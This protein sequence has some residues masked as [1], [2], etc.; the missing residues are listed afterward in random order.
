MEIEIMQ[1]QGEIPV[2][3]VRAAGV[4]DSSS[5]EQFMEPA[6][7]AIDEGAENLL[8]DLS[9]ISFMSSI[10]IRILN[11]LYFQLH[12]KGSPDQDKE[13]AE[14]IRS[15]EYKAPHL[16]LLCPVENV[17]K[18]LRMAGM[19]QYIEIFTDQQDALAAF[20]G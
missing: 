1:V 16:K 14:K 17:A 2:T 8:I 5:V 3:V 13:I 7:E 12:P 11:A 10:G 6:Q 9:G 18:V 4:F 19:D 20:S 15:G